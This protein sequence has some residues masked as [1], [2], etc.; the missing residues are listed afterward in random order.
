[1]EAPRPT[2]AIRANEKE[3]TPLGALILSFYGCVFRG[4][5]MARPGNES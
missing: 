4:P 5:V 3:L 2:I 1:M